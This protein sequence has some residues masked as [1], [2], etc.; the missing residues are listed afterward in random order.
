MGNRMTQFCDCSV[1]LG[2]AIYY[3]FGLFFGWNA[4]RD[5]FFIENM[6]HFGVNLFYW[7]VVQGVCEPHF[8]V[9]IELC[10]IIM[11]IVVF[12]IATGLGAND[13]VYRDHAWRLPF[14]RVRRICLVAQTCVAFFCIL[15]VT[16]EKTWLW[17]CLFCR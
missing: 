17:T 13:L 16:L 2:R 10:C 3:G 12:C 9:R 11:S 5:L 7:K 14:G 6:L 4:A 15:C 1:E 8:G